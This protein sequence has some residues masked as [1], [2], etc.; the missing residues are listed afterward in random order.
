MRIEHYLDDFIFILPTI[1]YVVLVACRT[2]N[3]ITNILSVLRNE[4]K[5]V[6]GTTAKVL[7]I[8]IDTIKIEARLSKKKQA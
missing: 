7:G 8:K 2:Y 4:G 1:P 5:N 3:D 6:E